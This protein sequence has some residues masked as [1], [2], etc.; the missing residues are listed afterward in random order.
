M[1]QDKLD[2]ILEKHIKWLRKDPAGE[3][4]DMSG[5][6]VREADMREADMNG[7]NM[8]ESDMR[9][10]YMHW[11]NMSGA[12]MSGANIDFASF[13]LWCG[14]LGIL[15]DNAITSQLLYHV[16]SCVEVS[17]DVSDDVKKA[18]LSPEVVAIANQF[19]RVQS[20]ELKEIATW[21][22]GADK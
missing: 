19:R 16:L 9:G 4:A 7:A 21:L 12:N 13:T 22:K 5:T 17:P 14:S 11:A 10:A 18:L 1:T 3:R 6:D 2:E 8:R 15:I 20:G